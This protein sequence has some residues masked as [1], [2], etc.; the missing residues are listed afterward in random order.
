[1]ALLKILKMGHPVLSRPA[2]TVEDPNHAEIVRLVDDMVE[3]MLDAPGIG[4][5]APQVG[6]GL[7]VVVYC[8]PEGRDE[9]GSEQPMTVMINPVLTPVGEERDY[10]VEGCLSLPGM[11]G[12]VPRYK[13]LR[14]KAQGLDGSTFERD[15]RGFHARVLQHEC[16]HLDGILYP[17]RMEDLSSF[18]YNEELDKRS[19]DE[20]GGL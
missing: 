6:V 16:D 1:M 4:L 10:A 11:S 7:R 13:N 12:V 5:A 19:D 2:Q 9:E 8:I 17:Q 20:R 18:G 14:I 15:V 3:T